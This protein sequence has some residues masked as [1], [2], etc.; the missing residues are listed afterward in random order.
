[1]IKILSFPPF[2]P[3]A[4]PV[5]KTL[6]C[7]TIAGGIIVGFMPMLGVLAQCEMLRSGFELW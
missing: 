6:V 5:L 7:F 4:A 3:I 1:M 2:R